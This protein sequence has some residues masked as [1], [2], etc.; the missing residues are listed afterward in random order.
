MDNP[1]DI[2]TLFLITTHGSGNLHN[3]D[4]EKRLRVFVSDML[5]DNP[6]E[7]VGIG[8]DGDGAYGDI[9]PT[10][11]AM[12][13]NLAH[14]LKTDNNIN[15]HVIQSQIA[16]YA[17]PPKD[18]SQ[19]I[20]IYNFSVNF[21]DPEKPYYIPFHTIAYYDDI[22]RRN[23]VPVKDHFDQIVHIDVGANTDNLYGGTYSKDFYG[24]EIH[25]L[26]GSTAAWSKTTL[27]DNVD[28]V[29]LIVIWDEDLANT[30]S[31]SFNDP[32]NISRKTLAAA[33][34][35]LFKVNGRN[36]DDIHFCYKMG[37]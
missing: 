8:F 32:T 6:L 14:K 3:S 37:A 4:M 22:E 13:I 18:Y 7:G 10:P 23:E 36:I 15:C 25:R 33:S 24:E 17:A 2:K 30:Q 35:G 21:T 12:A 27:L 1:S 11:S 28:K 9:W 20:P 16:S 26:A 31:K 5:P 34:S 19:K 29:Y